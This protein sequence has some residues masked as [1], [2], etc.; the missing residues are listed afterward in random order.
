MISCSRPIIENRGSLHDNTR[1]ICGKSVRI[2]CLTIDL[3]T[4]NRS[5]LQPHPPANMPSSPRFRPSSPFR[6]R[7]SSP[8]TTSQKENE[9]QPLKSE[10]GFGQRWTPQ[11]RPALS[12]TGKPEDGARRQSS[13]QFNTSLA[14][15]TIRRESL[16][17]KVSILS[18]PS[19][20]SRRMSSP[21]PPR[22]VT[23]PPQ[24]RSRH[25]HRGRKE[26]APP[27]SLWPGVFF[28]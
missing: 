19:I 10:I 2:L 20:T 17:P 16:T 6:W 11:Q 23:W 28:H 1:G 22:Y 12:L 21:P 26:C 15:D 5:L 8:D 25:L 18:N 27:C 13:I 9:P 4:Q 14:E 3:Y 24:H 7:A